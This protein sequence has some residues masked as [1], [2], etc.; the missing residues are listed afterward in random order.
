MSIA[1]E[2]GDAHAPQIPT[3]EFTRRWH[4]RAEITGATLVQLTVKGAD[5]AH[6]MLSACV[7]HQV[8][9][10]HGD[11][12]TWN[13]VMPQDRGT[14]VLLDYEEVQTLPRYFDL[15][16]AESHPPALVGRAS[17][18]EMSQRLLR[19]RGFS[20]DDARSLI[21]SSLAVALMRASTAILN[22]PSNVARLTRQV[23]ARWQALEGLT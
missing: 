2:I 21:R 17:L 16:Y 3:S 14:P 19:V 6:E 10:G 15:V 23:R 9:P 22:N 4:E 20:R 1:T 11:V 13:I 18:C 8:S 7:P 5:A 12:T